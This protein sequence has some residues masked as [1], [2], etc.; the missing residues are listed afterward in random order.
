MDRFLRA[1]A[2]RLLLLLSLGAFLVAAEDGTCAPPIPVAPTAAVARD[3]LVAHWSFDEPEGAVAVD[4]SGSGLDGS[5]AGVT[6]VTGV[7]AG[8]LAFDG[9]DGQVRVEGTQSP[10]PQRLAQLEQGTIAFWVRLDGATNDGVTPESLPLLYFGGVR[11]DVP[12]DGV[13]IYV[14]HDE[15]AHPARRQ[16]YFTAIRDGFPTLCFDTGVSLQVGTWYHYVVVVAPG[17]HR[18]YLDGQPMPIRYNAETGP[19]DHAFFADVPTE[20]ASLFSI[21][22]GRFGNGSFWHFNGV[23]DDVRIF[24]RALDEAEVRALSDAS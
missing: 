21:G 14:G 16:V 5:I 7:A 1:R 23:I 3:G 8:A 4:H 10:V 18:A 9:S 12:A 19:E 2:A 13:Q 24:D 11:D 20:A 6:R 17:D 15:V 22:Y